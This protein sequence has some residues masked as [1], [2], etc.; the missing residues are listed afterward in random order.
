[1]KSL[2]LNLV[3]KVRMVRKIKVTVKDELFVAD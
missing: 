1:M 2:S 3:A